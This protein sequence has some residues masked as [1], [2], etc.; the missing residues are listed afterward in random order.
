MQQ[1]IR[2]ILGKRV[3]DLTFPNLASPLQMT[4]PDDKVENAV[5]NT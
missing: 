4:I 1:H 3:S 5:H 2:G